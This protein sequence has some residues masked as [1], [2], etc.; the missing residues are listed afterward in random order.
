VERCRAS[1][2]V[3]LEADARHLSIDVYTSL[4]VVLGLVGIK[5]TGIAMLDPVVA[6]GVAVM[7]IKA[8]FEITGK[9]FFPILDVKL[10]DAEEEVIHAV[11]QDF[12]AEYVEYH[13]LRTRKAGHL[14]YIDM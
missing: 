8:A 13:K 12:S 10:P 14:R 11:M 1:D 3:A 5:V 6:I 2:S 9:A 7:I 4:G